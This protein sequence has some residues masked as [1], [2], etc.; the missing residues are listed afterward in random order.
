MM[1]GGAG[2]RGEEEEECKR[3][4]EERVSRLL[5]YATHVACE[6]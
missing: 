6:M 2:V 1:G 4:S 3:G 5:L